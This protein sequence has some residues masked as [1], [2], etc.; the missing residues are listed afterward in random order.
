M[1]TV[2]S[3]RT[4]CEKKYGFEIANFLST[5]GLFITALTFVIKPVDETRCLYSTCACSL[6]V[7][8]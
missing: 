6:S 1:H 5:L 7:Y 2:R 4:T 3:V 8:A